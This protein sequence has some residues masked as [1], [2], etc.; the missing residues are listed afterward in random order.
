M[1]KK[2][3][4]LFAAGGCSVFGGVVS[5]L[6]SVGNDKGT[7]LFSMGVAM[8]LVGALTLLDI[9]RRQIQDE[10]T[11][12]L[13][14]MAASYSWV[15]TICSISVLVLLIEI[16]GMDMGPQVVLG[17]LLIEMLLSFKVYTWYFGKKGVV[18]DSDAYA[19][20]D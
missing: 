3:A 17:V 6:S 12:Y 18:L 8:I 2:V 1:N 10:R 9:P 5:L 20:E 15:V 11:R 7:M 13:G 19:Y 14:A 16:G 4:W